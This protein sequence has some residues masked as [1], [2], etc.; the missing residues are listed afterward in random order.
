[1][2][3]FER[4]DGKIYVHAVGDGTKPP[5]YYFGVAYGILIGILLGAIGLLVVVSVTR[6]WP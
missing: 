2:R 6:V 1:M 5:A 4:R 3:Q